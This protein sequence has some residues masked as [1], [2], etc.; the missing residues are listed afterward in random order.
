MVSVGPAGNVQRLPWPHHQHF[1][2]SSSIVC[3]C[4]PTSLL[5]V[6]FLVFHFRLSPSLRSLTTM[7]TACFALKLD[8]SLESR[9]EGLCRNIA[10]IRWTL[11]PPAAGYSLG[12]ASALAQGVGE[13]LLPTFSG[14]ASGEW[15]V[16]F[17]RLL[18]VVN[19]RGL[20][21]GLGVIHCLI[22]RRWC[23]NY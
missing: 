20:R 22:N 11:P 23:Y 1:F 13:G 17:F 3:P 6:D 5:S 21:G 19:A 18:I 10:A 4:L 2:F 12:R 8:S 7:L 9:L 14:Q 15:S 16:H